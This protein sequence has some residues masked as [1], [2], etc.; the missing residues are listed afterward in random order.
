MLCSESDRPE[1]RGASGPGD[2]PG[3]A[4]IDPRTDGLL[5]RVQ[6]ASLMSSDRLNA[7]SHHTTTGAGTLVEARF[8]PQRYEPNYAYPLLVLF[9]GRGGDEQQMVRSMPALSWRNYVGL[10]LRGPDP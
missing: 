3:P 4:S 1:R 10:S 2:S 9:H 5:P 8:V 7:P 6:G